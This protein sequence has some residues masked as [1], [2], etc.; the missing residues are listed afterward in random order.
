MAITTIEMV[1]TTDPR[2]SASMDKNAYSEKLDPALIV[3]EDESNPALRFLVQA[4]TYT[5]AMH[6]LSMDKSNGT[7][8]ENA[9]RAC[10]VGY[11]NGSSTKMCTTRKKGR[12]KQQESD[13][14]WVE[15]VCAVAGMMALNNL[16]ASILRY[17]ALPESERPTSAS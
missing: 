17:A 11:R 16:V 2:L 10:V 1:S 4:P 9:V 13:S 12:H 5:F 14:E 3:D 8:L 15:E 6:E 7:L